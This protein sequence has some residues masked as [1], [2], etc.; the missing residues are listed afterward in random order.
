MR[1]VT[2][3]LVLTAEKTATER[4]ADELN[5]QPNL[6]QTQFPRGSIA[7]PSWS[8]FVISNSNN[9]EQ[10]LA[11]L[12]ERILPKLDYIQ[13]IINNGIATSGLV[14]TVRADYVDRPEMVIPPSMLRF[15]GALNT[16]LIIDVAYEE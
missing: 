13:D 6:L 2:I 11:E 9:I 14:I 15:W 5:L 7:K 10:P 16:E 3:R 4:I 8:T 12:Q 1:R